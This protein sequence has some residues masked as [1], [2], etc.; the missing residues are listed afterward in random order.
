VIA[1]K[2]DPFFYLGQTNR[3]MVKIKKKSCF[4]GGIPVTGTDTYHV[5]GGQW[6]E[7]AKKYKK[8]V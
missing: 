4:E 7:C 3:G 5:F 6:Q 1:A 8:G 2:A